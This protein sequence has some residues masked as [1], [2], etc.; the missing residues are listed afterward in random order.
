M[1]KIRFLWL[2]FILLVF[3]CFT[4]IVDK[5]YDNYMEAIKDNYLDKGWISKELFPKS[6]TYIYHRSELDTNKFWIKYNV[7]YYDYQEIKSKLTFVDNI[8]FDSTIIKDTPNWWIK[9]KADFKFYEYYSKKGNYY[10]FFLNEEN[11]LIYG[12]LVSHTY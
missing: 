4:D 10:Y 5:K 7:N 9:N 2:F 11:K 1:K 8:N 6:A 3:S 12:F